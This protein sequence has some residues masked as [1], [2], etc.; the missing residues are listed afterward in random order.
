MSVMRLPVSKFAIPCTAWVVLLS[1][2]AHAASD[3]PPGYEV[4]TQKVTFADLNLNDTQGVV[5]LYQRIANAA[6]AVCEPV[7]SRVIETQFQVRRCE[8][9]A[10][11]QAVRDVNSSLL[12]RYYMTTTNQKT[13]L[14]M[15]VR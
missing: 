6:D 11:A 2:F 8:R 15:V 5:A 4:V 14:T 7:D 1:P 3:L 13:E 12:T 10:I 9:Q